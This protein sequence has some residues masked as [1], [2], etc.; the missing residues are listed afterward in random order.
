M[1]GRTITVIGAAGGVGTT[2]IA[3]TLARFASRRGGN[4]FLLDAA[5]ESIVPLYLGAGRAI[6]G[7]S[8]GWSFLPHPESRQG[9][10]SV[11]ACGDAAAGGD[12]SPWNRARNLGG[13]SHD[14]LIDSGSHRY[15][16]CSPEIVHNTTSLVIL[17]PDIR[18]VLQ[19]RH[20]ERK[21]AGRDANSLPLYLLNQFHSEIPLHQEVRAS[22]SNHL[23]DRLAPMTV[24]DARE[25]PLALS[26]GLTVVDYAPDSPV[27]SDIVHVADWLLRS[28]MFDA[29]PKQSAAVAGL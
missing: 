3:V 4:I 5:E 19:V 1:F 13:A 9:V 17:S 10:I 26:E 29:Q 14:T 25:V 22:L 11:V 27:A 16:D 12:H 23:G 28:A 20:I 15:L 21:F 8:A 7:V 6:S 2:T 18:S 24:R